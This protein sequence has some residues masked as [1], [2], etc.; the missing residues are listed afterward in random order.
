MDG[1]HT[2]L[3]HCAILVDRLLELVSNLIAVRQPFRGTHVAGDQDLAVANHHTAASPAVARGPLA[4]R[5]GNLH[6]I[7]VPRRTYML[8]LFHNC[9]F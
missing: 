6:K 3:R 8:L 7:L 1:A 4:N 5:I 2:V 9:L